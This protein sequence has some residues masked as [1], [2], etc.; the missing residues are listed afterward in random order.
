MERTVQDV[1]N[2]I[3][4]DVPGAPYPDTVDSLKTGDP[5][6]KVTGIAVTLMATYDVI[7]RAIEHGANLIITHEPTFYNHLDEIDWLKKDPVYQAKRKLIDEHHISIW[8]F[9]DY[10]H[11]LKPDPTFSGIYKALNW[12]T[13]VSPEQPFLCQLP[14]RSLQDL[15]AEIKSGL[16]EPTVRVV[17]DMQMSCKKIAVLVG[18]PGGRMQI[19]TLGN[20]SA[21]VLICGEINEWEINEYVRDALA[22]GRS[23]A[24]IVI[25][26]S[27][28]EENGM[29]EV[30]PWLQTHLPEMPITFI[31]SGHALRSI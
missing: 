24:L 13:Y 26:H 12:T 4:A 28:S 10:L 27:I 30:I 11:S 6:Q 8:R 23:Q 18:A 29:Q 31:P 2:T 1:I 16:G 14:P 22:Q 17:G 9:H 20:L 25:G 21:D 19:E 3:V 7:Q 5:Q 15:V